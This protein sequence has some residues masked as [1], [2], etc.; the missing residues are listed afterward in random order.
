MIIFV[1]KEMVKET[2]R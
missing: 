1:G 2:W